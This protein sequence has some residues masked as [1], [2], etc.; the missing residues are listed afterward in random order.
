MHPAH[1]NYFCN[2]N[3]LLSTPLHTQAWRMYFWLKYQKRD[4]YSN[5]NVN[6]DYTFNFCFVDCLL[7][8]S[9]LMLHFYLLSHFDHFMYLFLS[10]LILSPIGII[11]FVMPFCT[12]FIY[13]LFPFFTVIALKYLTVLF[14]IFFLPLPLYILS[15]ATVFH[16][17]FFGQ[18][19]QY[20]LCMKR[21]D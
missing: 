16:R 6:T 3:S 8:I 21:L 1:S 11:L 19:H 7:S 20:F 2:K 10:C 5:Y 17:V 4:R 9:H 13:D 12:L 15:L 18:N 14:L